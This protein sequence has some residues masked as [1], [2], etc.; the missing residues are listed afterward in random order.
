MESRCTENFQ[1][2]FSS[3][4]GNKKNVLAIMKTWE[5]GCHFTETQCLSA[6]RLLHLN[7]E[8]KPRFSVYPTG[9]LPDILLCNEGKM[10]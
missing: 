6:E 8:T 1:L 5:N 3:T 7:V 9:T 4:D 2:T 10:N